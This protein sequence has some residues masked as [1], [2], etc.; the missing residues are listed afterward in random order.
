MYDRRLQDERII[1]ALNFGASERPAGI[2][3]TASDEVLLSTG[4]RRPGH[5]AGP[6]FTLAAGEGVILARTV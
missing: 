6:D 1:V 2:G 4:R 5:V 3:R